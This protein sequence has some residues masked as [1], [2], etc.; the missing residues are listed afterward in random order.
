MGFNQTIL[1]LT[2][3]GSSIDTDTLRQEQLIGGPP[4]KL[5]IKV[6]L[7][8]TGKTACINKKSPECI[9]D[10]GASEVLKAITPGLATELVNQEKAVAVTT[11][12]DAITI[13]NINTNT[14]EDGG[15]A[16]EG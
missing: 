6:T 5:L 10:R 8:D 2:V 15:R 13:A 16:R 4:Q 14:L 1:R 9:R 7:E 11:R 3:R 12:A